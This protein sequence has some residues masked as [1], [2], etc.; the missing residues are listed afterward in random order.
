[1]RDEADAGRGSRNGTIT[2]SSE[3][4]LEAIP[5]DPEGARVLPE[6]RHRRAAGRLEGERHQGARQ[7]GAQGPRR[8]GRS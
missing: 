8:G 2:K 3:D 7:P 5:G 1:M 4:Y 6:R